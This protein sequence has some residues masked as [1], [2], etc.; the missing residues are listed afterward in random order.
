MLKITLQNTPICPFVVGAGE[1]DTD[2][3]EMVEDYDNI[4]TQLNQNQVK[5]PFFFRTTSVSW[6]D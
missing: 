2:M 5:S 4:T 1:E 6:K 3:Q